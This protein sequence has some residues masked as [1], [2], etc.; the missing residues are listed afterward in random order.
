MCAILR[1]ASTLMQM[2]IAKVAKQ[3]ALSVIVTT[4]DMVSQQVIVNG[5]HANPH[6]LKLIA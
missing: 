2:A 1:V 5:I 3:I 4:L 6:I